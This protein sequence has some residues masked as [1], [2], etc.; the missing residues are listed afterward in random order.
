VDNTFASPYLFRPLELG[1]DVVIHSATKYMAGHGDATAGV[2]ATSASLG[3]RVRDVR[4]VQGGVLS[5]FE[6]W[7]TLRGL[8]TLPVRMSRQCQTAAE[9]AAWLDEQAWTRSVHY[10]GLPGH[11]EHGTAGRQFGGR[12]GAMIAFEIEGDR[13]AALRFID[14][15]QIITPG[16]SLGDVESLVLYPPLSSHRG[17]DDAALDA[18][19]IGP[20]LIRLSIGLETAN[21]LRRD[22]QRAAENADL[23]SGEDSPIITAP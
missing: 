10:P 15:L 4:S 5:P 12:F 23:G 21:D 16:T 17:L 18:M 14:S 6:A 9:V 13:E 11:P 1:V 20:S 3:R 7:L 22:L 19:G 2:V 8:R